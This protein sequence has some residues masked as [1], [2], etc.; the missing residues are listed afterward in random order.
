MAEPS[1]AG[2]AGPH[3][4]VEA[5]KTGAVA[6]VMFELC[7][8]S[9]EAAAQTTTSRY[10]DSL[11]SLPPGT[12][13]AVGFGLRILIALIEERGSLWHGITILWAWITRKVWGDERSRQK[14]VD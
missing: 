8:P 10:I 13:L 14:K 7:R 3:E 6:E 5:A 12:A 9:I 1:K 11:A 2:K 4:A